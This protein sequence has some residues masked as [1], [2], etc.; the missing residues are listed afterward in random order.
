MKPDYKNWVPKEILA[1][2][3][4]CAGVSLILFIVF[5]IAGVGVSGTLKIVLSVLFALAFAV[6]GTAAALVLCIR[7]QRQAADVTRYHR[8]DGEVRYAA[9]RRQGARRGLRQRRAYDRVR[10]TQSARCDD[11]RR[12]VGR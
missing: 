3:S 1:L 10:K 11:R 8:R 4:A 5:G 9:L 6:F 12:S 7:L 2:F